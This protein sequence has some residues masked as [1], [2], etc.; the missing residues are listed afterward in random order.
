[1]N[2]D[3]GRLNNTR[4]IKQTNRDSSRSRIGD[5]IHA[6]GGRVG[7]FIRTCY[8]WPAGV[9]LLRGCAVA[10]MYCIIWQYQSQTLR[11][12]WCLALFGGASY[13]SVHILHSSFSS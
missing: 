6:R 3:E 12:L 7:G 1:M 5:A 11:Q 2:Y 8:M 10:N 4:R 9:R 13:G